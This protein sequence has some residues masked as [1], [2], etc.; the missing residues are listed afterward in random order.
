MN[1]KIIHNGRNKM[2]LGNKALMSALPVRVGPLIS[3]VH[4]FWASLLYIV[5]HDS[6]CTFVIKLEWSGEWVP[7][8]ILVLR[9]LFRLGLVLLHWGILLVPWLFVGLMTWQY[10][11]FCIECQCHHLMW[12]LY[13]VLIL[14]GLVCYLDNSILL[15]RNKL[16][17]CIS[18]HVTL[19]CAQRSISLANNISF[20]RN[21][22]LVSRQ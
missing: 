18:N 17:I 11:L 10:W 6:S 15:F 4:G 9:L 21:V 13:L 1:G 7:G 22:S 14:G 16:W 5:C 12:V 3:H 20:I 19:E 8:G 2:F